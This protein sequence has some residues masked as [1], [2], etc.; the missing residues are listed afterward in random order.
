MSTVLV[1][2]AGSS[3]IKFALFAAVA[4]EHTQLCCGAVE[5]I[6]SA[7]QGRSW[8]SDAGGAKLHDE[9]A[10]IADAADGFARIVR[11]LAA[12]P[13]LPQPDAIGHRMVSSSPE[14]T[15]NQRVTPE[16]I[17]RLERY[18]HFAPLHT[19]PAL[20]I[21]RQTLIAYPSV[22]SFIALD[23][24][25]HR[26]LP[27]VA[28][29]LPVPSHVA[30]LGVH[31]YGAHGLSYE[32]IVD[33]LG[34]RIP[35]RVIVAHLGNG[36][37][38][39]A[40]RNGRSV[41]TSMGLTP[42][43][44][45]ISA[46]RTGETDPGVLLFLMREAAR[47]AAS[48]EEAIE[49]VERMVNRESGLLGVSGVSNDMRT[50][51]RAIREGNE[52]ARLAVDMYTAA[53]RKFIGAY[54]AVLGGADL[55]VFTGGIGQHDAATREEVCAGLEALGIALDAGRNAAHDAERISADGSAV[56]V[57]TMP[58]DEERM[59]V[60]HVLRL[61]DSGAQALGYTGKSG[62]RG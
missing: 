49:A 25:F 32:S 11:L 8:L 38:I 19:P 33:Q 35:E 58:P 50:L 16:V 17:V 10:E 62:L 30:A 44:G 43:G 1:L 61:M 20:H 3:S 24:W 37:S 54:M 59:I 36:S 6:G 55:L 57:R 15:E 29:T 46:T 9:A 42:T 13:E 22:P 48:A 51:R 18:V 34:A 60:R 23:S 39:T 53:I 28:R 5:G 40:I 12:H 56:T 52:A 21:L 41:D 31:R 7:G 27:P 45:L 26:N 4:S 47:T 2:N 14:V